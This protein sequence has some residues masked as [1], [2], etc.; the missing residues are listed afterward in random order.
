[1]PNHDND[2]IGDG[3]DEVDG[4]VRVDDSDGKLVVH[5]DGREAER[6]IEEMYP[7]GV[8]NGMPVSVH[9]VKSTAGKLLVEAKAG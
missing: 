1:M 3:L 8:Y 5:V 4:V 2:L 9:R 7:D 6:R